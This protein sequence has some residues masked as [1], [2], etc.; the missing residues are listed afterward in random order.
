[1][2]KFKHYTGP[3]VER[4]LRAIIRRNPDNINPMSE[5]GIAC[6]YHMGRGRN[7]QRCI[8][9]Q[10][11]FEQGFR[12]PHADGGAADEVVEE[13]WSGQADFDDDAVAVMREFQ[14]RADGSVATLRSVPIPWKD[15]LLD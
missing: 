5:D 6:L 1:M 10:W 7:L 8:I 13:L 9:G 4:Q 3:L 12:T 15:I 2:P 11:G 14:G